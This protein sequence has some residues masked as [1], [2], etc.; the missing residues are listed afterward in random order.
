MTTLLGYESDELA[1]RDGA[2]T[3]R[4][5][6]QQP[7]VWRAIAR[8]RAAADDR[9]VADLLRRP[10][11]RIVLTGAGSSAFAG[12]VLAPLLSGRLARR[13]DAVA[14]TDIVAAPRE[15]LAEDVPTLL[16][17][18][19]RSGDSPESVA[20]TRLAEGRLS[21]CFH[22]VVTCNRDGALAHEHSGRTRSRVL[23]LPAIAN[24]RGFAMTSSFT[25]MMLAARLA[26]D[27]A[28]VEVEPL[29]AAA[30]HVLHAHLEDA[31]ALAAT[32]CSRLVYLGSGAL[33]G[34]AA[35]SALKA[36]ELTAG[37]VVALSDSALGFRHG[38]KSVLD[39]RTLVAVFESTDPYTRRYD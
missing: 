1:A 20:A 14:S 13:V 39:E 27:G 24:D 17:S 3:A 10:E 30:E 35:E 28:P 26:L 4:E 22:L 6:A 16:V 29:A 37:G 23:L 15:H 32:G 11:L 21:E 9:F 18:L 34:L 2:D 8:D 25:G 7:A 19:A 36:L 5:I 12:R 33:Q 31:R 38:P